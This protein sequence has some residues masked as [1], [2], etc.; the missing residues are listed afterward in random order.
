MTKPAIVSVT[1]ISIAIFTDI[2]PVGMGRSMVRFMTPSGTLS[3][4]WLKA[5]EAPTMQYPPID[6]SNKILKSTTS[7][8]NKYPAIDENTTLNDKPNFVS[9]LR[10][11]NILCLTIA[12]SKVVNAC[13]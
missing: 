10:S 5:F 12:A 11:S 4:I 8:A 7:A 6:K 3:M 9:C 1:A 13:F 2:L